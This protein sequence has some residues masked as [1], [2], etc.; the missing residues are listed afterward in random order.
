LTIIDNFVQDTE[1]LSSLS[2]V[3]SPSHELRSLRDL[4][5]L[6]RMGLRS[7]AEIEAN[8]LRERAAHLDGLGD[9]DRSLSP[10]GEGAWETML[11]TLTPDPQL[12]SAGSSFASA[13]AATSASSTSDSQGTSLTTMSSIH[14]ETARVNAVIENV[15][16][17]LEDSDSSSVMSDTEAEDEEDIYELQDDHYARP[18]RSYAD[19]VASRVARHYGAAESDNWG[20]M[21]HIIRR[22]ARREDIPDEW[23]AEAGLSRTFPRETVR[24]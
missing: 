15:C 13:S 9:R 17:I 1:Q 22:L 5:P 11:T 14:N 3:R 21:Q 2:R 4:P 16:D 7:I 6:R 12:P 19:V 20:G 8:R 24:L 18:R 23:W 10:D